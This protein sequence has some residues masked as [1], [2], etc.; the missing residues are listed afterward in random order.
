MNVLNIVDNITQV[1]FG[2]WNAAISTAE[3][4]KNKYSIQSFL[5]YPEINDSP[6]LKEVIK[7]PIKHSSINKFLFNKQ[8]TISYIDNIL[9]K[10]SLGR[11]NTIIVTHGCWQFPTRWGA[12]LKEM[13]FLWIYVPHGMLEPWSLKQ[14]RIVKML[15]WNIW[16]YSLSK[17]ADSVRAVGSPEYK[18]L[19]KYYSTNKLKLIPNGT[20]IINATNKFEK[21]SNKP[22]IYLFMARLHH[23]KGIIPLIN[24]W[25]N[26]KLNMHKNYEFII[27]GP[28]DGVVDEVNDLLSSGT[29]NISYVGAKYG[30]EKEELLQK[31]SFY[32]L[33]SYS[34]GFPTSILEAM[35]WNIV[36]IISKGCNF[37][38][39]F[40]EDI[41]I[42]AE[43]NE[44]SIM[45]ALNKSIEFSE[46]QREEL[47]DK[48]RIYISENYSIEKISDLQFNLLSQLLNS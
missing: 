30:K 26:S 23:K 19:T 2:I 11:N 16:E 7:I 12:I 29:E 24:A 1:N 35:Q 18:N 10:Y 37:P 14:K 4:L 22:I 39:V 46:S 3:K 27:A 40:V 42:N 9:K 28:D 48:C 34:E 13:G 38:E 31:S 43:P 21:K 32:L 41:A 25:K 47:G 45:N 20:T 6:E 44:Y 15:Y 8:A 36:P 33:P 5:L 17:K